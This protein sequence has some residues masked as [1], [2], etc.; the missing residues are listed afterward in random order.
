MQKLVD[1]QFIKTKQFL[2]LIIKLYLC[3]FL[4]PFILSLTFENP[5]IR[6][7]CYIL[8]FV[9]QNFLF[10]FEVVQMRQYGLEYIKD[11]WNCIDLLQYS[12][13][14]YLFMNKLVTQ[15]QSDSFLE[16]LFS[17]MIM[18]LSIYKILYFIRIYDSGVDLLIK[19]Y[20]IAVDLLPFFSFSFGLLFMMS[21]VYQV[22]HMG[23]NDPNGLYD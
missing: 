1:F 8:C 13:F 15:F 20:F 16:I 6:N 5:L 14:M 9:T 4:G 3:G 2:D 19:I 17:A 21:K 18:F 23:I 7:L 22:M 12:G 10:L 11:F